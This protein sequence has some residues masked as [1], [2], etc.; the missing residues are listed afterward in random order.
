MAGCWEVDWSLRWTQSSQPMK[1]TITKDSDWAVP[2]FAKAP[3]ELLFCEDL[4]PTTKLL[5]IVLANQANF[6][7]IDKSVLDKRIGIHRSTRIRCMKELKEFGLIKG[8]EPDIILVDPIPILRKLRE[9]DMK[10][11]KM[12]DEE[13]LGNV[14]PELVQVEKTDKKPVLNKSELLT[15]ATS[16]WNNY[17]P[18][19]YS[20][21]NRMSSQMLKAIDLHIAALGLKPKSYND[22]FSTLKAGVEHSPFWSNDNTSKT[23]QS[24]VGIG[25]PQSKKYQNVYSLYNEGLNYEKAEAT[26][27]EDRQDEIVLPKRLR[28]LIDYYDELHFRYSQECYGDPK[29]VEILNKQIIDTEQKMRDENLDPAKFRLKFAIPWPTDIPEPEKSREEFWKYDDED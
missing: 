11:R 3:I 20:K 17:R 2:A 23:L 14:Q 25:Q 27:E 10:S 5:W 26:K 19:N 12:V 18:K 22:F 7:P 6:K 4:H 28:K 9:E 24:I 13:I 1:Y 16:A 15:D 29:V 8:V 21:V